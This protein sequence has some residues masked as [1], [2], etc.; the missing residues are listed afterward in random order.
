MKNVIFILLLLVSG[1]GQDVLAQTFP[2]P[3]TV[4]GEMT[5][6]AQQSNGFWNDSGNWKN[7]NGQNG[8]PG[9]GDIVKIPLNKTVTVRAQEAARIRFIQVLGKLK[10]DETQFTRL[11]VETIY[12]GPN[13]EFRVGTTSSK[14]RNNRTAEIVFIAFGSINPAWDPE[15]KSR[16]LFS[17][18]KVYGYGRVKGPV[19]PI[20]TTLNP[21]NS[22]NLGRTPPGNW[23][24]NDSIVIASTVFQRDLPMQDEKVKIT[25]I[26]GNVITVS[27]ALQYRHRPLDNR[28]FHIAHI[29]RNL[30]FRSESGQISKRG[31][32]MFKNKT[33]DLRYAQFQNLGRTDKSVVLDDVLSNGQANTGTVNNRR[34][35]YAL[36]FHK[37]GIQ[38][39]F[40]PPSKVYN[41]VVNGAVGW[42]FVNHSSHVDF[43]NNVAYNFVGSGF[44]TESGDELG[45]FIGNIA[46][47]GTG[48]PYVGNAFNGDPLDKYE[49]KY[50]PVRMVFESPFRPQPVSDFGFGGDGFWFQ[51]PALKV[52]NN[53]A[54][55]CN[56]AGM[57]WFCTG[58]IENDHYVGFPTNAISTVYP[59]GQF[60]TVKAR[61]WN[62][63]SNQSVISDLPL[64]ECDNFQGYACLVGFRIR[65]QNFTNRTWFEEYGYDS[66]IVKISGQPDKWTIPHVRQKVTNLV[67]WNNEQGFRS[68]YNSK[69]DYIDIEAESELR[70]Y[71]A[72]VPHKAAEFYHSNESLTFDQLKLNGY[73]VGLWAHAGGVDNNN[74]A[75]ITLK[76]TPA[77][78]KIANDLSKNSAFA[79]AVPTNV[80]KLE[81]SSSSTRITWNPGA[82]GERFVIRISEDQ[83]PTWVYAKV[84]TGTSSS[85]TFN[86]LTPGKKYFY[87]VIKG[88]AQNV[89]NWTSE[90]NFIKSSSKTSLVDAEEGIAAQGL[91][92]GFQVYPN[93]VSDGQIR[94]KAFGEAEIESISLID[95]Q[96]RIL[97]QREVQQGSEAGLDVSHLHLRGTYILLVNGSG[98]SQS[99][100]LLLQ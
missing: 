1:A 83:D 10:L 74:L 62:H 43:K 73:G 69:T 77:F 42:G 79:C 39:G 94:I 86:D 9:H 29:T 55:S 5:W 7:Q 61:T 20:Y 49:N 41:C 46:I 91:Q 84:T 78:K 98:Q 80:N 28:P 82:G 68:R 6:T 81:L 30:I 67:L 92:E 12:V 52:R 100:R 95:L 2:T 17:E 93:P 66:E 21:G 24:V 60:G 48:E 56:G 88:C 97:L 16:G 31:H 3:P 65:F 44:V 71:K 76:G 54:S 32:I 53:I 8:L 59:S 19:I 14:V 13:G 33:V 85:V 15:Q 89:S 36:H 99:F 26:N 87:Q 64:L 27:P 57:I 38:P 90:K 11:Y 35:R 50:K 25:G 47:H 23:T 4:I 40:A 37:N 63:S 51:G 58:N 70:Y 34:G 22:L 75:E 45:N 96:G 18:G 72:N